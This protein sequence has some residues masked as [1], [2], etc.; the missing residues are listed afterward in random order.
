MGGWVSGWM[1]GWV[2]MQIGVS[3]IRSSYPLL[4]SFFKGL[5][6]LGL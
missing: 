3:S 2:M 6:N 1:N 4:S 5:L